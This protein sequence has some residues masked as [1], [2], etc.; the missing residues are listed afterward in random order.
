[1]Q[2]LKLRPDKKIR[3]RLRLI[4]LGQLFDKRVVASDS[5]DTVF[6][7]VRPKLTGLK[8]NPVV[9]HRNVNI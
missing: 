4:K 8:R 7:K 2:K 6:K 5:M 3:D 1:M 9:K